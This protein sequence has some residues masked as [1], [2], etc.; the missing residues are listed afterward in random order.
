MDLLLSINYKYIKQIE[1][2]TKL[3]EIRKTIYKKEISHIYV[4]SSGKLNTIVGRFKP[5]EVI[6]KS[7]K[8]I[9]EEYSNFLGVTE[10][11]FKVYSGKYEKLYIIKI[12]FYEKPLKNIDLKKIFKKYHAPQMYKY[13]NKKESKLLQRYFNI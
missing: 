4:H 3:Y 13:L 10:E 7:P 2:K 9:W 8:T 11:E 6:N 5:L 1:K 12:G